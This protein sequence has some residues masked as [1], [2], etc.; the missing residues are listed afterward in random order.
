MAGLAAA[1]WVVVQV[2]AEQPHAL[3]GGRRA[4]DDRHRVKK[5]RP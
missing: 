2:D 4:L 3:R 1:I 5:D